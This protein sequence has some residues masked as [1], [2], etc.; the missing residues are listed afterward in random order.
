MSTF[1]DIL[2][3][4]CT[5]H[6]EYTVYT[7]HFAGDHMSQDYEDNEFRTSKLISAYKKS[8]LS[9]KGKKKNCA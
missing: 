1:S 2:Q 3:D 4:L 8:D 7:L 5:E 6:G 9:V